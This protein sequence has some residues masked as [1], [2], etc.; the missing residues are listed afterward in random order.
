ME[1]TSEWIGKS[2]SDLKLGQRFDA[3]VIGIRKSDRQTFI[4]APPSNYVIHEHEVLIIVTPMKNSDAVANDAH[5]GAVRAP[6]TLRNR[7]LQST[8]WTPDQ[9]Q[10]MLN[11]ARKQT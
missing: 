3:G 9:I 11:Q 6:S 5:G 4:Y 8:K 10:E 7:V 2:I 1:S